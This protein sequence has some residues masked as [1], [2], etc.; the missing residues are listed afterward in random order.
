M[1]I[2]LEGTAKDMVTMEDLKSSKPSQGKI[3]PSWVKVSGKAKKK[4]KKV[5]KKEMSKSQNTLFPLPKYREG[6]SLTVSPPNSEHRSPAHSS[7]T[8]GAPAH[9]AHGSPT[10]SALTRGRYVNEEVGQ[11]YRERSGSFQ[12]QHDRPRGS[13]TKDRRQFGASLGYPSSRDGL[14]EQEEIL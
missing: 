9:S 10:K 1:A 14:D 5:S 13:S 7:T 4:S 2:N 3:G 6:T 12:G 8:P 11:M